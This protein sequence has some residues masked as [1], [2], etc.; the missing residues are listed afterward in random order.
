MAAV[1]MPISPL[2]QANQG[3]IDARHKENILSTINTYRKIRAFTDVVIYSSKVEFHAHRL[4][5]ASN[6]PVLESM[7]RSDMKEKAEGKINLSDSSIS[8]KIL[9]QILMYMYSCKINI[10][11]DN[12]EQLLYASTFL[13]MQSLRKFCEEFLLDALNINN[14]L[15]IREIASKYECQLLLNKAEDLLRKEFLAISSTDEFHLISANPLR[16]ILATSDIQVNHEDDVLKSMIEW[17]RK[18]PDERGKHFNLLI[19]EVRLQFLT[20]EMLTF[21]EDFCS[22]VIDL[23]DR[24]GMQILFKDAWFAKHEIICSGEKIQVGKHIKPRDCLDKRTIVLSC[25]GYDGTRCLQSCLALIPDERKTFALTCMNV[26]RQDHAVA[27][28]G[29]FMYV[30]GGFNSHKGHLDSAECY[31]PVRNEWKTVN[32]MITKRK[33]LAVAVLNGK[34]YVT[35]GLDGNFR[36]L[37][38]TEFYDPTFGIWQLSSDLNEPRYSHCLVSNGEHLF[39]IGG[40]KLAS[41]E[42]F[43]PSEST[44][45]FVADMSCPRAGATAEFFNGHIYVV[46]GRGD[47]GCLS[48]VEAYDID[49]DQWVLMADATVPRWRAS[50]CIMGDS[51]YVIGGRNS[52][53]QYLDYVERLDFNEL[54][55]QEEM[56][57][58]SK[59]MGLNCCTIDVPNVHLSKQL[60]NFSRLNMGS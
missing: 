3:L 35:G 28:V 23:E 1:R 24:V 38:T 39:A 6:S 52:S 34:I 15:G 5:L 22:D 16:E 56:K 49:R 20:D 17:I 2:V 26:A 47:N 46:G 42:K 37:C 7:L 25:G 36:S 53:W 8:P 32:P 29:D 19:Q 43:N 31:N 9:E 58:F 59:L 54:Q 18:F 13:L 14:C 60:G 57:L 44:W 11:I 45:N 4:I 30:I 33:A 10:T 55:W 51:M 41:V 50:S 48:T 40:W 27:Q 12:V 21:T